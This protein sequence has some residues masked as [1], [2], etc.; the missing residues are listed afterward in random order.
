MWN[1]R[2]WRLLLNLIDHLP[3][4]SAYVEAQAQ[5]EEAAR[6]YVRAGRS[7]D[8][9]E[10]V[11]EKVSEWSSERYA[12]ARIE[13]RLSELIATTVAAAGGKPGRVRYADRPKTAVDR[14]TIE[15]GMEKHGA[16]VARLLPNTPLVE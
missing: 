9:A 1:D 2:R 3:R 14:V 5:D 8:P 10:E 13:D 12:L 16:L 11:G 4:N 15:V 7:Q 6:A